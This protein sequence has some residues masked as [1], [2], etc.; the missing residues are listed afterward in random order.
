MQRLRNMIEDSD[1]DEEYIP[2]RP[3]W[4]RERNNYFDNYDD[5]DFAIRFRLSKEATLCLLSKIEHHLEYSSNR[6]FSISPVNQLLATL[7]YYA[8]NWTQTSIGDYCGLSTPTANKIVHR[9]SAAIAALHTEY[10]KFPESTQEI[11]HEQDKFYQIARF[12]RVVGA[13]DCTHIRLTFVPLRLEVGG[14]QAETF[15]NRKGYYSI[16]VQTIC[17]ANLEITDILYTSTHDSTIFNNSVRKAHFETGRYGNALLLVDRGYAAKNYTMTPLENPRTPAEQLYNES[18][19]RTRNA[20][21]RTYGVWK[22]RFPV[23]ALGMRVKLEKALT[24]IIA[25]AVLHNMLRRQGEQLPPDDPEVLLPAPWDELLQLGQMQSLESAQHSTGQL[26][27]N[28]L[29]SN[30]FY[31]LL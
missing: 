20:I 11:R 2:R 21:E 5:R 22:R 17:N 8:T 30:Y 13:M 12:P 14:E 16:N 25:T 3:R 27:R 19:I 28:S 15:R 31:S 24:I 29:I 1:S 26:A 7:R 9:V 23:L 10:I 18:Q 6:N 4:I